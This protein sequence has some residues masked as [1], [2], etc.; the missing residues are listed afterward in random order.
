MVFSIRLKL[1]AASSALVVVCASA[2]LWLSMLEHEKLYRGTVEDALGTMSSNLAEDLFPMMG[3][4]PDHLAIST[5]L[6]A[7]D[8]YSNIRYAVVFDRDSQEVDLYIA[9]SLMSQL[10]TANQFQKH[11]MSERPLGLSHAGHDLVAVRIIGEEQFRQGYLMVVVDYTGPLQRANNELLA[12]MLPIGSFILLVMILCGAW[13]NRKLLRPLANLTDFT[14]G[15]KS[16]QSYHKRFDYLGSD[17]EFVHLSANINAMLQRIE[18]QNAQSQ[19]YTSKLEEQQQALTQLA[20]YDTLTGLPNRKY[21]NEELSREL[22][23]A[24]RSSRDLLLMFLDLDHFKAINDSLGHEAG[25]ALLIKVSEIVSK[26]LRDGD[27]FCRLGGDEFTIIISEGGD[28][29]SYTATCIAER[30][31]EELQ[32]PIAIEEWNV[33]TGVSIGIADAKSANYSA[34]VLISNADLAMY[35]A[36]GSGRNRYSLFER[37]LQS[38]TVRKMHIANALSHA[39]Q[40][41]EFVVYYQPKVMADGTLNGF[42]ALL[43]WNSTFDGAISPAE[44][45]PIAEHSGRIPAITRW[46]IRQVFKDLAALHRHFDPSLVISLNLSAFDIR[47]VGLPNYIAEQQYELGVRPQAI[48]FEV[49]ES[50]YLNNFKEADAFFTSLRSM[51]YSIALD[52]FGTGYS[53]LSYLTQIQLDTLKIDRSFVNK[54]Q[55]SVKDMVILE[56]IVNLAQKLSLKVCAEGVEEAEQWLI[57]N[58]L[59]VEQLQGYFFGKPVMLYEILLNPPEKVRAEL[60]STFRSKGK[61]QLSLPKLKQS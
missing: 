35:R 57:L 30:I 61:A 29:V 38:D 54:M 28:D 39:L 58:Q 50:A 49:T 48:E 5:R 45:I 18:E 6:L 40:N 10:E 53:S 37:Q 2:F 46:V 14:L 1:I 59:G 24:L 41:D 44:F 13:I 11:Q 51:G 34:A 16:N 56:A 42:E 8:N 20:N 9:P 36:K 52:D 55:A 26:L 17:E 47:E 3:S 25:D 15:I 33:Q 23:K 31:I 60:A 32:E 22:H 43:R 21:F 12:S 19:E 27:I 7:L 4:Q